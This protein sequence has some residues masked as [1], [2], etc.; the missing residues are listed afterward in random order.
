[1][2]VRVI[3]PFHDKYDL[4]RVY[5]PG[6]VV[7]FEDARGEDI[8]SRGLGERYV[9]S[10]AVEPAPEVKPKKRTRKPKVE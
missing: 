4:S 3:R 6:E 9:P 2:K 5:S 7:V 10:T 8:V 1:M